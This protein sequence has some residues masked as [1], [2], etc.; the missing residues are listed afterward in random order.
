MRRLYVQVPDDT[1]RALT[2]RA[3]DERRSTQDQAGYELEQLLAADA[4]PDERAASAI[5]QAGCVTSLPMLDDAQTPPG[6]E[7]P[8]SGEADQ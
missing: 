1:F 6:H 4:R 5:E 2:R 8:T 3:S 7:T